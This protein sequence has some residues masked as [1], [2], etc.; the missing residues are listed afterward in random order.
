MT[1]CQKCKERPQSLT[2]GW[3]SVCR[4]PR[5]SPPTPARIPAGTPALQVPGELWDPFQALQL[6]GSQTTHVW[7]RSPTPAVP[8]FVTCWSLSSESPP[9][10]SSQTVPA[11]PAQ[12]PAGQQAQRTMSLERKW[13]WRG[14]VGT[15]YSLF[16]Q[17]PGSVGMDME[18]Q[19]LT[20][21]RTSLFIVV[22][23]VVALL[24]T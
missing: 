8:V 21:P 7:E 20:R 5:P 13:G 3:D 1:L 16:Q 2:P 22:T 10:P 19:G 4:K 17:E 24:T 11:P 15:L 18:I 14:A 12:S 9:K 6:T 23:V